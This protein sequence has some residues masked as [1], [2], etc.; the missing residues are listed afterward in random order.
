MALNSP[1]CSPRPY[2]SAIDWKMEPSGEGSIS[3]CEVRQRGWV[4]RCQY[5]YQGD[6][7]VEQVRLPGCH[8]LQAH[9]IR[10][11]DVHVESI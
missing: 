7:V 2:V 4:G 11:D 9:V 5:A 6:N 1:W 10:V 3:S 8:A